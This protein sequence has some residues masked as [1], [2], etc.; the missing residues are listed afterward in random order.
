MIRPNIR[1]MT[2]YIPGEQPRENDVIKLN[3]NEN[4]YPPAPG[5]VEA[6]QKALTA[7]RLRK[8]PDPTGWRFREAAARL[9]RVP[10]ENILIGNGSDDLLTMITRAAVPEGGLVVAPTPSYLLYRTLAE[11]QGARF[12]TAR[13]ENDWNLPA[14]WPPDHAHAVFLANP[15]SPSGTLLPISTLSAVAQQSAA[16]VTIDEAYVDFATHDALSLVQHENVIVT[17][18][19]SKSYSLAGIRFGYA[20]GNG[21]LIGELFKVK[22]S[23]NCDA[24]SLVAA[25][26][27]LEDQAHFQ[28]NRRLI[29]ASRGRL[30]VKLRQLGFDVTPSQAN[31]VWCRHKSVEAKLIYESLKK[32]GILV[33]YMNYQDWPDG[34]RISVGSDL[35]LDRLFD[36]LEKL[37]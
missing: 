24:L 20:I 3:T 13:F 32:R 6:I 14:S 26:A 5:V 15:N 2:G 4:P 23:Y 30:E 16:L 7:D 17:R 21:A 11:I 19:L 10:P 29:L 36:E 12:E 37:I 34:L 35:E 27:A 1:A 25:T 33:R 22:D 8:Y 28:N 18:S 9:H 31:F